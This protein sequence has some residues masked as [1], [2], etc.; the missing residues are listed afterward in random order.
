MP[1]VPSTM[2]SAPNAPVS[3]PEIQ[4]IPEKYYGAALKA[5][6]PEPGEMK[7]PEAQGIVKPTRSRAPLLI[8]IVVLL[9]LGIGGAFVY[10]NQDLV[11]PKPKPE[12]PAPA[13]VVTPEPVS[14]PTAPTTVSATS[15]SPQSVSLSWAKSSMN[16]TGFRV[17]RADGQNPF[18]VITNLPA[19]STSFLDTSVQPG[20]AY[21]YRV[22]ALNE[23]GESP[24]STE[25]SATSQSLP[26]PPPEQAKLPPAG[27]DSDSDGITDLEEGLYGTNPNNPDTDGD[28]FLDGNEV[29]NLYNPNGRA[30][31]RLI[32]S[33]KLKVIEGSIGWSLYAFNPWTVTLGA[34]DGSTAT[35]ATGQGETF[36]LSVEDNPDKLTVVNWYLAKH[37]TVK[38]EQL[39]QYRSK[40]G[41]EGIISP[42]TLSTYIPW[43]TKIFVFTY[44]LDGQPF[45]NYR[46]TYYMTLNSL[47]LKGVPQEV[48]PTAGSPITTP[49][50]ALPFEPSATSTG[51]VAQPL[52]VVV[53][54][55]GTEAAAS[56]GTTP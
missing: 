1:D 42:D 12:A 15:T 40:K 30:P 5:R 48:L 8:G 22:V 37:P 51:V 23:G 35:I 56:T 36:K 32:D 4:V 26:P 50:V 54:T 38:A 29:Y 47:I 34:T 2:P 55:T 27:L 44:D 39:L 11:F 45:I 53:T 16:E 21:R 41:Y 17:E 9:L 24:A 18:V 20:Q 19:N 25:A 3:E 33:G 7:P 46:T 28:G 6:V 14:P 49:A 43:G 52:P 10:F 13:P 31:S